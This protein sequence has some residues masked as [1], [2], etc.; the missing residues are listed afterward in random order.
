VWRHWLCGLRATLLGRVA[1]GPVG[2]DHAFV[3]RLEIA[4][5][6]PVVSY[7]AHCPGPHDVAELALA[8]P[9]VRHLEEAGLQLVV[10]LVAQGHV[11]G[12][13]GLGPPQSG[14]PYTADD[15]RFLGGLAADAAHA[16]RIAQLLAG[17]RAGASATSGRLG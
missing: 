15:L 17:R 11:V 1:S 3:H 16:I 6:D 10:P 4:P 13:L 5:D 7:A 14:G 2:S 8:T 9:A 12:L